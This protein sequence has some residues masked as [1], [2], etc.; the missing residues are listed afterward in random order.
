MRILIF[1]MLVLIPTPLFA[2]T[3]DPTRALG[4]YLSEQGKKAGAVVSAEQTAPGEDSYVLKD[5]NVT[6]VNRPSEA[7]INII[8]SDHETYLANKKSQ[9]DSEKAAIKTKLGLSD[10]DVKALKALLL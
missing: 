3:K 10:S 5:W 8:I 6:G 9:E 2:A 7:E 4:W 1:M